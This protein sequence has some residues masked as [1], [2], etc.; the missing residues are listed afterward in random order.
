MSAILDNENVVENVLVIEEWRKIDGYDNYEVSSLGRVRNV[1][2]NKK[3]KIL[4]GSPDCAGYIRVGLCNEI[5]QKSLKVHILVGKAFHPNPENK[6]E[7]NHL[8]A[9][10]DNRACMLEWATHQENCSHATK[11]ITKYKK[12]A[13]HKINIETNEIVKTYNTISDAK[14]DGFSQSMISACLLGKYKTH[15]GFIWKRVTV[16]PIISTDNLEGEI[17]YELKDSIYDECKIF[18]NYKV[19]NFGRV[20]GYK[21]KLIVPNTSSG[22]SVIQ[23]IQGKITKYMK[24]HRMVLMASNTPNL[25]NKPEVDH[26]DSNPMNHRLDNLRWATKEDQ[27]NNINTKIK[28][29]I[30]VKVINIETKEEKIYHGINKLANEIGSSSVTIIKYAKSG[31]TYKG[32]KFKII[33]KSNN[34]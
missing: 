28:L 29:V 12:T 31:K 14:K 5:H 30:N 25:E 13:V 20:K 1:K 2:K 15:K 18:K 9:K 34:N 23:L 24:V 11:N 32:Y 16:K 8:G 3:E 7:I 21:D 10:D 19:S 22:R 6:K 26:I 27:R 4:K 33:S 17:W